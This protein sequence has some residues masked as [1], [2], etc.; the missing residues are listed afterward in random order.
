[1]FQSLPWPQVYKSKHLGIWERMGRS[2]ELSEFQHGTVIGCHPCNKISC[3]ISLLLNIPQ[4]T[5]S[6]IIT[7]WQRLGT[8]ATKPQSARPCKMME[9][10]ERMLRCTVRRGRQLSAESIAP[11]LQTSCGLQISSRTVRRELH[12]MGF[13]GPAAASKR[14]VFG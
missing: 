13:H 14:I 11:D 1:M 7:K 10:C 9:H 4:S 12:R 2:Q 8:T 3:E 5:V 6:G